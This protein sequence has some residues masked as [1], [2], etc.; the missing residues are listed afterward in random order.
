[1]L[2]TFKDIVRIGLLPYINVYKV[3]EDASLFDIGVSER[4]FIDIYI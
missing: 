1:M 4:D 3:R 2:V